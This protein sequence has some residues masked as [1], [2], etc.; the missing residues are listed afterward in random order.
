MSQGE[1]IISLN[2]FTGPVFVMEIQYVYCEIRT[3]EFWYR[4]DNE[5]LR[6][7][8]GFPPLSNIA[9]LYHIQLYLHAAYT[10]GRKME[11]FQKQRSF[12]YLG[13]PDKEVFSVFFKNFFFR[14][15]E[16]IFPLSTLQYEPV[17]K[18]SANLFYV[19]A[20]HHHNVSIFFLI[21]S[22]VRAEETWTII[23]SDALSP[24][25]ELVSID[26]FSVFPFRSLPLF[27]VSFCLSPSTI[28]LF[29]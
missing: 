19:T 15:H 21:L 17:N 10:K 28:S 9:P 5:E 1:T 13:K 25:P 20:F 7:N 14:F 11:T 27:Y 24:I 4:L 26:R 18:N 3:E 12:I 8:S 2:S 22:E 6:A 23:S 29:A 16:N